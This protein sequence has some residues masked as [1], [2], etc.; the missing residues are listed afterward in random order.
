VEALVRE[1]ANLY[2]RLRERPEIAALAAVSGSEGRGPQVMYEVPF[3]FASGD[4]EGLI[5]R[6]VV[7]CLIVPAEGPP[8]IL[9]FK[10]GHPRPEHRRQVERYAEAIGRILA[11]NHV[12]TKI[13]YA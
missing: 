2:T 5:L 1:A 8:V 13:L 10:T 7:D 6:G 11:V 3:S 4:D 12:E 9:E